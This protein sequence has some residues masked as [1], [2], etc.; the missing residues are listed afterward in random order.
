[1]T[2]TVFTEISFW[3]LIL[4]SIVLPFSIYGVLMARRAVSRKTVLFFGL[5]LVFIAGVN[6]YLLQSVAAMAKLTPSVVDD[7]LFLSEISLA[8][9]LL[10]ALFGGVGINVI[11][12]VLVE[13][14]AE[15]EKEFQRKHP[16]A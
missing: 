3:L 4:F 5:V 10:P 15:S 1:M 6:V 11:S 14:L 2:W 12:H 7:S 9:Y 8:L 13:H 16:D